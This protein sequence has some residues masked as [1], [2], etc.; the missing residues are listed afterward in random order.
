MSEQKV[1]E[2]DWDVEGADCCDAEGKSFLGK[3]RDEEK[4]DTVFG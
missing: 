4:L 2:L 3:V 1:L